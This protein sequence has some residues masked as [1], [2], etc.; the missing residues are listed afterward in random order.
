MCSSDLTT[1]H[2]VVI[3]LI[4][5]AI[6]DFQ[7]SDYEGIEDVKELRRL[8]YSDIKRLHRIFEIARGENLITENFKFELKE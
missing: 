4:N 6:K 3:Q 7:I 8:F 5:D 1:W 2:N